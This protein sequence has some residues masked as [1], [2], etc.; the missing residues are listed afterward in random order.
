[1]QINPF[2]HCH[3]ETLKKDI[4]HALQSGGCKVSSIL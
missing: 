4:V 3:A 1:M 2:K